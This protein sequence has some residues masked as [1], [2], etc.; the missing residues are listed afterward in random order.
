LHPQVHIQ[1]FYSPENA[2]DLLVRSSFIQ[3][4]ACIRNI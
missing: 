4:V 3:P 1:E 2:E